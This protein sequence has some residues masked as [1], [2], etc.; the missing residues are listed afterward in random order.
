MPYLDGGDIA[1][2]RART[3]VQNLAALLPAGRRR[4]RTVVVPQPT[5]SYV[6]KKD[7][8]MLVPGADAEKVAAATQDIF[9]YLA[10]RQAGGHARHA[11]SRAR[12]PGKV[13]YQMPCHLRAQNMGFKTRDVLQLIPGTEVTVVEKC[14]AMDGTWGMK[15]EY[16][17][18]SLQYAKKAAQEMEA[19]AAR[20]TLRDRLLAL[21]PPDRGGAGREAGAPDHACCARRT[22][23]PRN[24]SA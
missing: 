9:E 5:C 24:D 16:Y 19:A 10:G 15:K 8:P 6:L 20:T 17:P 22:A 21:R 18:I 4:E 7:Y 14:T 1:G 11:T 13:A 12:R 23:F 3:R 2:R